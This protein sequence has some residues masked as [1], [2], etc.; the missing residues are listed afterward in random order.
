MQDD[1]S[2]PCCRSAVGTDGDAPLW[3]VGRLPGH[4]LDAVY[5]WTHA[6]AQSAAGAAVRHQGEV[7]LWV[8]LDGLDKQEE[9]MVTWLQPETKGNALEWQTDRQTDLISR[10]I[11]GHVTFTAVDTH[12]LVYY[13]LDL[14]AQGVG[15]GH[16]DLVAGQ[17][18]G[19]QFKKKS[20]SHIL[21]FTSSIH[22]NTT[23]FRLGGWNDPPTHRDR[24]R[25]SKL[26]I[27]KN[28][29]FE[30]SDCNCEYMCVHKYKHIVI[31]SRTLAE[32]T[33][34]IKKTS[35]RD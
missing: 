10:V 14:E 12:L 24:R 23:G 29:T 17:H 32:L 20:F 18:T 6:E 13:S 5:D 26:Y 28:I 22:R 3:H 31:S 4:H 2:C 19:R 21:M 30:K 8:E 7:S 25:K 9:A 1:C 33:F 35:R 11:A 27:K 16:S 15:F 34:D